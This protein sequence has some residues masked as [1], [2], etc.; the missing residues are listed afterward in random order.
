MDGWRPK[1]P[2]RW[3]LRA[4]RAQRFAGRTAGGFN[5]QV[6]RA[7][8]TFL[9]IVAVVIGLLVMSTREDIRRFRDAQSPHRPGRAGE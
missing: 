6:Q 3:L 9:M 7:E 1:L 4:L 5:V 2:R 8:L